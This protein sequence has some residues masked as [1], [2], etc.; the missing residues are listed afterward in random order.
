MRAPLPRPPASRGGS[1]LP[2]PTAA[3]PAHNLIVMASRRKARECAL[4][5]LFQWD[6]GKDA[7]E[8]VENLF[9]SNTRWLDDATLRSFANELFHGTV[10]AV[11]E[12]DRVI[13]NHAEH[14]RLERMPAVDRNVLRLAVYELT[15]H[16]QAPPIVVINE[17]LEIAR[18][19]SS[20]ESVLFING[21][22][23]SI[24]K[25]IGT[26]SLSEA[27]TPRSIVENADAGGN[28]VRDAKI[29]D[30]GFS[31]M[32][33]GQLLREKR[34]EILDLARKH[35]ARSVRIFGSV[36]RG[37]AGPESDLDFL[38]E[39]EP[40]RTLLDMGG[41]LMDLREALGRNVDVV[42]ERGLRSSIRQRVL[43][44]AVPL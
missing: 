27:G 42:T 14:W 28:A 26:P 12:L 8:A 33:V 32:A 19:F 4:Q 35:G 21:V 7:P 40:G 10:S 20:E 18:K 39:M 36:A 5:M 6:L 17:A 13:Q 24:R 3:D 16:K 1:L 22:L 11:E 37:E 9:W 23:D 25:E 34:K 29:H 41:L 31:S 2:L 44:E 43:K 38:V 15:L 30:E